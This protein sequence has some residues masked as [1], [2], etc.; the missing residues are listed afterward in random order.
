[1]WRYDSADQTDTE[2][3]LR[4]QT[5]ARQNH[6][7]R[8]GSPDDSRQPL[9]AA[10][11]GNEAEFDFRQA[12]HGTG[13]RHPNVA[14]QGQ[15]KAAPEA[16]AVDGGENRLLRP[17]DAAEQRLPTKGKLRASMHSREVS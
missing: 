6:F 1:M 13:G 4:G 11:T 2:R 9:G 10:E 16:G 17:L 12:H 5:L 15:L 7:R 3:L 14:G 8:F